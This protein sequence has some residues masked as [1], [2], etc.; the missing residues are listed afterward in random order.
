MVPLHRR[1][2]RE[3]SNP[4]GRDLGGVWDAKRQSEMHPYIRSVI[5]TDT[6]KAVLLQLDEQA[7]LAAT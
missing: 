1:E 2:S 4:H 7:A 5:V 6:Y 3:D